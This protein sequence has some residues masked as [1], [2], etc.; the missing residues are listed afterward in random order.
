[1]LTSSQAL[2]T[3]ASVVLSGV[4]APLLQT[5]PVTTVPTP[6]ARAPTLVVGHQSIM[7][8]PH[9]PGPGHQSLHTVLGA[10]GIT[11]HIITGP[12]HNTAGRWIRNMTQQVTGTAP[13]MAGARLP[14]TAG[15][16]I[17]L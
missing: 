2:L 16:S 12:M 17:L 14:D 1:M 13:R 6:V 4:L 11:P 5:L 10:S 7:D 8:G 9:P 15:K 3:G